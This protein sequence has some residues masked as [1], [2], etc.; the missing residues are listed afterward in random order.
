MLGAGHWPLNFSLNDLTYQS[1]S[2]QGH[3]AYNDVTWRN[4]LGLL[5]KQML[6]LDPLITHV[7]PLSEWERGMN[8]M[9]S[10]EG[11]KVL[12]YPED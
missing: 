1:Q 4:C 5:E 3:H 11:T 8:L 12:L 6:V 7:L 9:K 2:I 10:R